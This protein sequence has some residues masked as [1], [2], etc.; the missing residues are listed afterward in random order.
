V[1][2]LITLVVTA[3]TVG[4]Q[5]PPHTAAIG[6]TAGCEGKTQPCWQGIVPGVTTIETADDAVENV[7]FSKLDRRSFGNRAVYQLREAVVSN[8]ASLTLYHRVTV[9][10]ILLEDCSGITVGDVV[11]IGL[12]THIILSEIGSHLLLVEG[13]ALQFQL[14]DSYAPQSTVTSIR[15]VKQATTGVD[16]FYWRGFAPTWRYCDVEPEHRK[17]DFID[18]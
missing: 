7:G 18:V 2:I 3:I 13:G 11:A 14:S 5:A 1:G 9:D 12:P 15:I 6:F 16:S 17:C 4:K 8:C 10:T